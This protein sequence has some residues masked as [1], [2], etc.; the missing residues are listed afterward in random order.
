MLTGQ[1]FCP[2]EAYLPLVIPQKICT[3]DESFPSQ[4]VKNWA[5]GK[6]SL[7]HWFVGFFFSRW[8]EGTVLPR[9]LWWRLSGWTPP[10]SSQWLRSG[11]FRPWTF[12]TS[13][14][15]SSWDIPAARQYQLVQ[16]GLETGLGPG[17]FV[18]FWQYFPH[19]KNC[20]PHSFSKGNL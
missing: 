16:P 3:Q 2:L 11:S 6:V 1:I 7:L 18:S 20:F 17:D 12:T 4:L 8:R 14:G 13:K 15:W 5:K 19:S 10:W 9:R